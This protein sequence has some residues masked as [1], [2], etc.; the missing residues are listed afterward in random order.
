[1]ART[2]TIGWALAALLLSGASALG[3][4]D[5][6]W[7]EGGASRGEDLVVS[8]A[9]F[10]PGPEV[11]SWFGHTALV[12]EDRRLREGR[13]YNYGMFSFDEKMLVKFALGRLEFWVDDGPIA[14]TYRFYARE[15]RDVRIQELN[16]APEQRLALARA[17]ADNV[18]P[19]NREYLYHHYDDNCATRPRDVIDRVIG[20]ELRKANAGPA[21]MT[22]REHT[23]RHSAVSPPMSVLLDFLMNDEIDRP[24]ARWQEAFLPEELEAQVA[25]ARPVGPDGAPAP[26]VARQWSYHQATRAPVPAKPPAYGPWLLLMGGAIGGVGAW[27]GYW[28]RR[29]PRP[30]SRRLYGGY[31]ALWG[32]LLGLP[33]TVLLLMWLIT[34]HTVTHRNENLLLANPL[35]LLALPLGIAAARG[36]PRGTRLLAWLW[37]LLWALGLLALGL[38]AIPLLNQDNW[39][40]LALLLPISMGLAVSARQFAFGGLRLPFASRAQPQVPAGELDR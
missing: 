15:D 4:A 34:E 39:R 22:L 19:H 7:A 14:P 12:V 30:L 20:G 2:T 3:Q 25:A 23:R 10:G 11:V 31:H 18:L 6:P 37:T 21:R 40:L 5:A 36:S 33:G 16:L 17:L 1:M 32:L 24:I 27:L 26:L 8:L 28:A 35:T 29:Q 38:K 13:L 9:T